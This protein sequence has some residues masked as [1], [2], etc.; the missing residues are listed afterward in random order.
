MH[1]KINRKHYLVTFYHSFK[2]SL[3]YRLPAG[4]PLGR[5]LSLKFNFSKLQPGNTAA[6]IFEMVT[7]L[8]LI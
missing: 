3:N 7:R 5:F 2:F 4:H 1:T 6:H 8:R